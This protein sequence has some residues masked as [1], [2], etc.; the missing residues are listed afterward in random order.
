MK[1]IAC[2]VRFLQF[3]NQT[4]CGCIA[5]LSSVISSSQD[6][7]FIFGRLSLSLNIPTECFTFSIAPGLTALMSIAAQAF[8]PISLLLFL[9]WSFAWHSHQ[10][11]WHSRQFPCRCPAF[12][13]YLNW[14]WV[15]QM[16]TGG[17][18]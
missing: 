2:F 1:R 15:Y 6:F 9:V 11:A 17:P 14:C 4:Y 13:N 18:S 10:L 16:L 8:F 5:I 12:D 3:S 7:Y